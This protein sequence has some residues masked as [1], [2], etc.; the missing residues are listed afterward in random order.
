MPRNLAAGKAAANQFLLFFQKDTFGSQS[1]YSK[2][3]AGYWETGLRKKEPMLRITVEEKRYW[4]GHCVH[5]IREGRLTGPWVEKLEKPW[6]PIAPSIVLLSLVFAGAGYGQQSSLVDETPPLI[7]EGLTVAGSAPALAFGRYLASIQERDPFTESGPID[8][9]IEASLPGLAKHGSMQ[10]VRQT[11]ASERSEYEAIKF[12]GDSTVRH[13]V[14]A[15]YLA[16]EERAEELPYSS[17]A[18]TPANYRF[19]Y[20]ASL[21]TNGTAVY[22]FQIAPK[23][24]RAGLIR[25]QIWIDS[26]TGIAVHQAGRFVK[27]PSIFIRR[28]EV[29]RDT[30]LRDGLPY[31]RVTHVA[32]D[33][34]LAGRAELMITERPLRTADREAT[35]QL[36]TQGDVR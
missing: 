27:R 5:F 11:G 6:H 12:D 24:K 31:T 35:Q 22:I 15:R 9:E 7:A 16:A 34:R 25:G 4:M 19:R 1:A 20:V 18:V 14:I 21:E 28:I 17:V 36:I 32:I 8:V 13:Q 23:K 10:A 33:T 30:K 29:A 2:A 26:A 3:M